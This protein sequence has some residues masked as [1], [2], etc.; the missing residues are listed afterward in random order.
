MSQARCQ[1]LMLAAVL[2]VSAGS[3]SAHKPDP[4]KT[5]WIDRPWEY[6][7]LIYAIDHGFWEHMRA[8]YLKRVAADPAKA[9]EYGEPF[10]R[11]YLPTMTLP[12]DPQRSEYNV[13]IVRLDFDPDRT[14]LQ[15]SVQGVRLRARLNRLMGIVLTPSDQDPA[16]V[17]NFSDF[18]MGAPEAADARY[19]PSFCSSL[20]GDS[21]PM[22]IGGRYVRSFIPGTHGYF[23]CRE[24]AAQLYDGQRPYI[25]VT[26]Y[27][28]E[29]DLDAQL[30]KGQKKPPMKR[31]TYIKPFLG[32]SRFDSPKKPVIGNHQGQWYCI[33]DCPAGDSPGPIADMTAWAKRSGWPV[34]QRPKNVRE[35]M[36]KTPKPVEFID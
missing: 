17:V 22:D 10:E 31:T 23:G 18:F 30:K 34:P 36:N 27:E 35:F 8:S 1:Q 12:L 33:T 5:E 11:H 32:F 4:F 6:R 13:H 26:S 9:A 3:S 15:P 14:A 29:P 2:A 21:L 25:D 28:T 19:S 7:Y 24:W 16:Y 20:Q